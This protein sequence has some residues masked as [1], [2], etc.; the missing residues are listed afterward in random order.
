MSKVER[1]GREAAKYSGPEG[2]A[3][4]FAFRSNACRRFP[5]PTDFPP[6]VVY[7]GPEGTAEIDR[8]IEVVDEVRH[9]RFRD[10]AELIHYSVLI[11]ES[12]RWTGDRTGEP[13]TEVDQH[14][15]IDRIRSAYD[16][17]GYRHV[18]RELPRS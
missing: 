11:S 10:V 14:R 3:T 13:M 7:S 9:E 4:F 12:L 17:G 15:I 1:T 18:L 2:E 8:T 6:T 5:D 16:E